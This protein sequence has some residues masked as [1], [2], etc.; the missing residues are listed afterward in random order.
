MLRRACSVILEMFS[1]CFLDCLT[2]FGGR[3]MP[4]VLRFT[5]TRVFLHSARAQTET[6]WQ[7][8]G[9]YGEVAFVT[10]ELSFTILFNTNGE[11]S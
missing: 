5:F 8:M 3:V 4:T 2:R 7:Y 10:I 1:L 6:A 9:R 11:M